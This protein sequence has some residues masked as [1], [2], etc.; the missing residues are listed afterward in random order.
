M[1]LMARAKNTIRSEASLYE[2]DFN[3]WVEEQVAFME[4][5]ALERLDVA[6]LME[7]IADM[8]RSQKRAIR[9]NL[10]VLLTHLL[11]WQ[12]QG[13]HRSTG[14]AGSIVEHRRCIQE[15]IEDSPS[16][17]RYPSAVFERCYRAA[18]E[19]AAAETGLPKSRFPEASPYTLEQTLDSDFLPD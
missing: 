17:A 13:R 7:E 2:R 1:M 9:S 14:W 10:V 15:E 12:Y 3:L 19:Q 5:G 8:A 11:K 18:R 6:N 4:A 16:L